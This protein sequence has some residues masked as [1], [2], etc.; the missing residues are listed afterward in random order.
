MVLSSHASYGR[1]AAG[2]RP[3]KAEEIDRLYARRTRWD[4]D[5]DQLLDDALGRLP[6][7]AAIEG[8]IR[9]VEGVLMATRAN[10]PSSGSGRASLGGGG[11]RSGGRSRASTRT[12]SPGAAASRGTGRAL[13]ARVL[14]A[15]RPSCDPPL[16][17][18]RHALGG[19]SGRVE[20]AEVGTAYATAGSWPWERRGNIAQKTGVNGIGRRKAESGP[21]RVLFNPCPPLV[22]PPGAAPEPEVAG[23]NP[24][25]MLRHRPLRAQPAPFLA[26]AV[27]SPSPRVPVPLAMRLA[28]GPVG[29][30]AGP[31]A[32]PP[33]PAWTR[34]WPAGGRP[35]MRRC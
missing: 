6:F 15:C 4:I 8:V 21:M 34:H 27:R 24:A 30:T 16:L 29:L 5:R 14:I 3:L 26:E 13:D 31:G 28:R 2:N 22:T 32:S 23:S 10:S 18:V 7:P 9:P 25:C 19:S 12:P 17:A 35:D 1:G 20:G 33:R 11:S